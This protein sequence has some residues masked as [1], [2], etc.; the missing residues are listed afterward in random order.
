MNKNKDI[1]VITGDLIRSTQLP[2][3]VK[4]ELISYIDDFLNDNQDIIQSIRFYRGDSFQLAVKREK[5][6][7]VA[8]ILEAIILSK[9]GTYAR[10][11]IGIGGVSKLSPENVLQSEGEAFLLSGHQLD[12]MKD[13]GRTL[14][15]AVNSKQFQPILSASLG[16]METIVLG[17]KTGQAAVIAAIPFCKTQ[18][19]IAQ[20]LEISESAVSKALKSAQWQAIEGFLKGF[21]ETIIYL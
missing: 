1:G 9:T 7:F 20:R 6:V 14:K 17:W 10:I 8:L 4:N 5:A 21:E 15:I 19:E 16:I 11:G 18:K 12:K 2:K 13:E 3:S